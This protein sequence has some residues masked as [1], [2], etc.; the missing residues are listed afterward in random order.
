MSVISIRVIGN[1]AEV[2]ELKWKGGV[3]GAGFS[4]DVTK[5]QW[6]K[7]PKTRIERLLAGNKVFPSCYLPKGCPNFCFGPFRYF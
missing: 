6:V 4:A 1:V 7:I 3:A 5:E 2:C